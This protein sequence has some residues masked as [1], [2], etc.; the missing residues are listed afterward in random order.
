V[1]GTVVPGTVV[2]VER[3]TVVVVVEVEVVVVE[4]DVVE[5]EVVV[6]GTIRTAVSIG[7]MAATSSR[8]C[9]K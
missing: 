7:M 5:L 9:P 2:V 8:F 3:G 4:V 1:V 6:V